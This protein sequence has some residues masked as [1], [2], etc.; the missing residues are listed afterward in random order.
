MVMPIAT[1]RV[2]CHLQGSQEF[3]ADDPA[4]W[5]TGEPLALS[6]ALQKI[7]A[8]LQQTPMRWMTPATAH[9][10]IINPY[11]SQRRRWISQTHPPTAEPVVLLEDLTYQQRDHGFA[12]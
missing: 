3:D 5:V 4:A 6:S 8:A 10:C 2:R 9:L 7:E 12:A 11:S 1:L